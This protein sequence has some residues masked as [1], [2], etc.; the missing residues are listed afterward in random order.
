MRQV[1]IDFFRANMAVVLFAYGLS[2]FAM[3]LAIA[4]QSRRHSELRMARHLPLLGT[5][6]VLH[7]LASWG[8]VFIPIQ[9]TYT[10]PAIIIVLEA[11]YSVLTAL[12]FTFL[13]AFGTHLL[14]DSVPRLRPVRHLPAVLTGVWALGFFVYPLVIAPNEYQQWMAASDTWAR[15]LVGIP[16]SVLSAIGL[17]LQEEEFRGRGMQRLVGQLRWAIVSL[18]AYAVAAGLVV[19]PARFFPSSVLNS[20]AFLKATG[21]PVEL[22]RALAGLGMAYFTIRIMEMF[23][24]EAARRMEEMQK[25]RAVLAERDRIAREL[26]DGVIQS[27]YAL[28]LGIENAAYLVEHEPQRARTTLQELMGRVNSIIQDVRGYI[29]DLRLPG[30]GTLT[31]SAKLRA[32]VS[33]ASRVYHLPIALEVRGLDE[34]QLDSGVTNELSLVVK[35]AISNAARHGRPRTIR[36]GVHTEDGDL[37]LY[38]QDDGVGFDVQAVQDKGGYGLSNMAKRAALLGGELDVDSRPGEGTTVMLRM[39]LANLGAGGASTGTA[40]AASSHAGRSPAS[41]VRETAGRPPAAPAR[42]MGA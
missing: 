35:E 17:G 42:R 30:E 41:R 20:E 7:A 11:L 14:A 21:I 15:Y 31:L 40:G 26:H 33:E 16:G 8:L 5:F 25:M 3:G 22:I 4:L 27:L 39:P 29:M 10:P 1:L 32:V 13:L 2:F 24:I 9:R 37:V 12:T 28:G 34:E 6:G 38:V 18:V 36:V 19:P 23:D